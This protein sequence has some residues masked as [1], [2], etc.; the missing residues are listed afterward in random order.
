MARAPSAAPAANANQTI[1]ASSGVMCANMRATVARG[2]A[3][4]SGS[5]TATG[6]VRRRGASLRPVESPARSDGSRGLG[7]LHRVLGPFAGAAICVG[8]AVGAGI[9]RSPAQIA[10]ALPSEPWIFAVWLLGAV[11]ASL[12]VLILAEMAASVPR[13]GG[14]VAY[15][16]LSFGPFAAFLCGWSMLLVTWPGSL[17]AVAV[18][19]GELLHGGVA[20]IGGDSS[21]IAGRGIA[22]VLI[23][24]CGA[25]NLFG[26]RTGAR[27]EIVLFVLKVG[28]LGGLFAAAML[29][30]PAAAPTRV[31][32]VDGAAAMPATWPLLLAAV[33]GA[34]TNVIFSYDG[35]ADAVYV[36]GETRDPGR[37]LPR[38]LFTSLLTITAL[39]LLV[40]ASFVRVLGVQGLA[41]AEFAALDVV[42]IAFGSAG[43]VV[44]T[45]AAFLVL[46][47]AV[48]A[49]FLT[50]P[51]I[52]RLLAEEG[53]AMPV[54]GR[55]G[56]DGS[57]V[58]AT[59][60]QT[61]LAIAFA[62]TNSYDRLLSVTVPIMVTTTSLVALGL[63]V[64]RRRAPGRERPF[65]V[66]AAPVVV[67]LQVLLGGAMLTGFV[68]HDPW[69]VAIDAVALLAGAGVYHFTRRRMD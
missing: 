55:L 65:R 20:A 30:A 17:A 35:Y 33:G 13:V 64:Q 45:A 15:V 11:V 67:G 68:Q 48:N 8:V 38:A 47:G 10:A 29:A 39:Y 34:M 5:F 3:H 23:A 22:S 1:G 14:L 28:L 59:I 6:R 52:A 60:L 12:D 26:L 66:P 16:R 58:A 44:L 46:L 54:L 53:L 40:N 42:R 43:V 56:A 27:L 7:D 63:L 61:L 2:A 36:A 57:A 49:Y 21:S 25:V 62:L 4:S 37:A 51:R 32:V 50:G 41:H 24:A 31:A 18:V 19:A 9:L 69:A